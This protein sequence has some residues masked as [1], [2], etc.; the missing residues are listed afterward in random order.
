MRGA[1]RSN[2]LLFNG[3]LCVHQIASFQ[4]M[5]LI[6]PSLPQL[7][8]VFDGASQRCGRIVVLRCDQGNESPSVEGR[9]MRGYPGGRALGGTSRL[10]S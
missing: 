8:R 2:G 3:R 1:N 9:L 10:Q 7:F 5:G 4:A 6:V